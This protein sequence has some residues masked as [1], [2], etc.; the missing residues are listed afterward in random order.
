MNDHDLLVRIDERVA[1]LTKNDE[2]QN[3]QLAKVI[4]EVAVLKGQFRLA[5]W[6]VGLAI[7][8]SALLASFAQ[9]S[10]YL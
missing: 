2:K 3:G 9:L 1:T 6:I 8:I 10:G 4:K 5:K 7:A